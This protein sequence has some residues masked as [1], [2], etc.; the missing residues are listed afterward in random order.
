LKPLCACTGLWWGASFFFFFFFFLF[1]PAL[2]R[3]VATLWLIIHLLVSS[4]GG[5]HDL[6]IEYLLL[7]LSR[8]GNGGGHDVVGTYASVSNKTGS[9][10]MLHVWSVL[11]RA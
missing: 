2:G 3:Y 1:S 4:K 10:L 7:Y 5:P 6:P 11:C 9:Y 8:D